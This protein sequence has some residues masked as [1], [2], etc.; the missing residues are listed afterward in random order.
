MPRRPGRVGGAPLMSRLRRITTS[1]AAA[2]TVTPVVLDAS[3]PERSGVPSIVMDLLMVTVPNAPGSR[4][5]ISPP[6]AVLRMA[7]ANVLQ[8]AVRLQGS[9][10][11]PTPDTQVRVA[12]PQAAGP[13]R[14]SAT[15]SVRMWVIRKTRLPLASSMRF[16]LTVRKSEE[17]A[18]GRHSGRTLR[19]R[20]LKLLPDGVDVHRAC[21]VVAV[22][23]ERLNRAAR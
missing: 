9:A 13:A 8:G 14:P 16:L 15:A 11:L 21:D 1:E 2:L 4:T 23:A 5:L 18:Q 17:W 10:S 22:G 7:P 6:A 19:W 20:A 3:T 12:C